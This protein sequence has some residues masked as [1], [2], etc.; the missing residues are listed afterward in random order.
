[1]P[2]GKER[3]MRRLVLL[4]AVMAA[5]LVLAS[6]VALAVNRVGTNG[7]DTLRGTDGSDN[8]SGLG[9]EDR[10]L[11]KGGEDNLSGGAGKD[12]VLGGDERRPGG[13]DKNL[14]G[15][16][17]NDVVAAG[18]GSDNASGGDGN[19]L[20]I[21]G[22][23]GES[24]RDDLSG[25]PGKDVIVVDNVPTVKDLVAC[26]SGFDRVLADRKDAVAPD[27]E[28]VVV[29]RGSREA[30]LRQEEEFFESVPESFFAGLQ[31]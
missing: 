26:G 3:T 5:A 28:R 29:V 9:G 20:L 12:V 1:M 17:G 10:L 6:G 23:L 11:G 19:D 14:D 21:D 13:G 30:V 25:G 18:R 16:G 2:P 8:L 31:Q 15:G 22:N 24:S 27:C 4:L 7:P